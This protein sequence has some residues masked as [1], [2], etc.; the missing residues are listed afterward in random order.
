LLPPIITLLKDENNKK[1]LL[2]YS[3]KE[4]IINWKTMPV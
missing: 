1:E 3:E 4:A 2:I